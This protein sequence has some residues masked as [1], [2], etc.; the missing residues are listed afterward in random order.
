MKAQAE[1]LVPPKGAV[2]LWR[3]LFAHPDISVSIVGAVES[4]STSTD[5]VMVN[6]A[7]A[8]SIQVE[9]PEMAVQID[10]QGA[11]VFRRHREEDERGRMVEREE[12]EDIL[13]PWDPAADKIITMA[14]AAGLNAFWS[15][16]SSGELQ[17]E[18]RHPSVLSPGRHIPLDALRG[19]G[20]DDTAFDWWPKCKP[21]YAAGSLQLLSSDRVWGVYI[22]TPRRETALA[23]RGSTGEKRL[24]EAV[25]RA[26]RDNPFLKTVTLEDVRAKAAE[27]GLFENSAD[28][29]FKTAVS[30]IVDGRSKAIWVK[31]GRRKNP[32]LPLI[33]T[34]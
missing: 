18:G 19:P 3:L 20:S 27:M 13:R 16:L 6:V 31:R 14:W 25:Q 21:D 22:V 5:P 8:E 9:T 32:S 33:V 12:P 15:L 28:R 26:I 29:A 24:K 1:W 4:L 30:E 34:L 11:I 10:E 2:P 17:L 7:D 23:K